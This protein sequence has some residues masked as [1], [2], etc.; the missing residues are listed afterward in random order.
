VVQYTGHAACA[1][2][3]QRA[4]CCCAIS[5]LSC[6]GVLEPSE[7]LGGTESAAHPASTPEHG[8]WRASLRG[9]CRVWPA[10]P[11]LLLAGAVQRLAAPQAAGRACCETPSLAPGEAAMALTPHSAAALQRWAAAL[12]APPAAAPAG[13]PRRG[14]KRKAGGGGGA[15]GGGGGAADSQAGPDGW[16]P[17]PAQ[18]RVLLRTCLLA[19]GAAAPCAH[20]DPAP[21][22]VEGPPDSG[23]AQRAGPAPG[24]KPAGKG[25]EGSRL[26]AERA[27][28]AALRWLAAALALRAEASMCGPRR[29]AGRGGGGAACAAALAP[30]GSCAA[31]VAE[32]LPACVAAL[33]RLARLE[34]TVAESIPA[35]E[36]APSIAAAASLAPASAAAAGAAML[37]ASRE[38]AAYAA[39]RPAAGEGGSL[40]AARA[41]QEAL[42]Q[43]QPPAQAPP[44]P[45]CAAD[46]GARWWCADV[47]ALL[48]FIP[49]ETVPCCVPRAP[50]AAHLWVPGMLPS[51][52]L[53]VQ[54]GVGRPRLDAWQSDDVWCEE[55]VSRKPCMPR[56]FAGCPPR[57]LL[58]TL[59]GW[60]LSGTCCCHSTWWWT[61]A[62]AWRRRRRWAPAEAWQPC[63]LGMLPCVYN[64]NGRLPPL[65]IPAM[66]P[67]TD[68][69]RTAATA[70]TA[71][72]A[73]L[74][75]AEA[76][77]PAGRRPQVRPPRTLDFCTLGHLCRVAQPGVWLVLHGYACTSAGARVTP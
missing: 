15:S 72:T 3:S 46:A 43:R 17:S 53:Q 61:T 40:A 73:P 27:R 8:A 25:L 12:L 37:G 64:P 55:T 52:A 39:P 22:R 32:Q 2:L 10:L 60:A 45:G 18:A 16:S 38:A 24:H 35:A 74:A 9:L 33:A 71:A 70:A 48:A 21:S 36:V 5:A 14:T 28:L 66:T 7:A 6:A 59:H 67:A 29:S 58:F 1:F 51:R 50:A 19:L 76:A 23:A 34:S 47:V 44:E 20:P 26:A 4:C 68:V 13:K 65:D 69:A 31:G 56:V 63:A 30:E 41:A 49:S 77:A 11:P 75:C 42:L 54:S 57:V 62:V